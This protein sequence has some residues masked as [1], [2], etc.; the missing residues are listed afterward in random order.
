MCGRFVLTVSADEVA[1]TFQVP[2]PIPI[3]PRYNIAP[4]QPVLA[5]REPVRGRREAAPLQWGLVP[6]WSK[7]PSIGARL[8]NARAETAAEKP[9]F[10]GAMRYRRCLVPA[11]GYYEWKPAPGGRKQPHLIRMK[12]GIPFGIAGLWEQ[13]EGPDGYLETVALLTTEANDLT[14]PI[15][16]RMPVIIP[17]SDHALWLD[18]DVRATPAVLHLLRPYADDAMTAYPVGFA[19]NNPANDSPDLVA[20]LAT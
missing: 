12:D 19:V 11:N 14:R 9:S 5:V 20:P 18:P 3:T 15:H 16:D 4:S 13:W 8:I 10:R 7:D 6:G 1:S 2:L 17:P